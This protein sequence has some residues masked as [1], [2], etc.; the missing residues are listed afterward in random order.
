MNAKYT[1]GSC[2]VDPKTNSETKNPEFWANLIVSHSDKNNNK[3]GL[4]LIFEL[5]KENLGS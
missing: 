5:I 1:N 3:K 2:S 4:V